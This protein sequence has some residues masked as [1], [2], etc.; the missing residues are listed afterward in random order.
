MHWQ[1]KERFNH[2]IELQ[3]MWTKSNKNKFQ[4]VLQNN[5]SF[6]LGGA[7]QKTQEK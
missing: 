5:F 4:E 3:K 1:P 7:G 2:Y 6:E